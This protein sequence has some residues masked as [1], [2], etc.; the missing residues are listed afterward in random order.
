MAVAV[1]SAAIAAKGFNSILAC[2]Q[3]G[4]LSSLFLFPRQTRL[5]LHGQFAVNSFR[6]FRLFPRTDLGG[7]L[8]GIAVQNWG[9]RNRPNE[10]RRFTPGLKTPCALD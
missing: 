4:L 6:G 3:H 7:E 8:A 1:S 5:V 9:Y 2:G 10:T